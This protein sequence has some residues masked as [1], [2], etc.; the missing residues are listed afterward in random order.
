MLDSTVR[1][2][3]YDS[4]QRY[5]F[6]KIG[7]IY[8]LNTASTSPATR[9]PAITAP[10]YRPENSIPSKHAHKAVL[11]SQHIGFVCLVTTWPFCAS[12]SDP[13]KCAP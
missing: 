13:A 10:S 5:I 7:P 6:C 2:I 9:S 3:L 4:T 11:H 8:P 1:M 12:L